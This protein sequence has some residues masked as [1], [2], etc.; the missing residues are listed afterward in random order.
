[1]RKTWGLL[2]AIQAKGSNKGVYIP[3]DMEDT[4][5]ER[6]D[7]YKKLKKIVAEV[8]RIDKEIVRRYAGKKD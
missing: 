2:S 6:N 1:V 7:S 5:R 8:S 4:V 3:V